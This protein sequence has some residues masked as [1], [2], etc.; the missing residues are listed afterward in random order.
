MGVHNGET[1][2]VYGEAWGS[3]C[4]TLCD[5]VYIGSLFL[6]AGVLEARR[7]VNDM[8]LENV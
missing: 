7:L 1:E 8:I 4:E 5:S 2:T 6:K 3:N